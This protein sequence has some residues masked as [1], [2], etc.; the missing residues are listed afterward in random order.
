MAK[1]PVLTSC[2]SIFID[3]SI[4]TFPS[5]II[6]ECCLSVRRKLTRSDLI[7]KTHDYKTR[8]KT[9]LKVTINDTTSTKSPYYFN[10]CLYNNLPKLSLI[11]I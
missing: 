10:R 2:R 1:V 11:H 3:L 7:T 4:L 6:K 9:D 5:L 8:Q